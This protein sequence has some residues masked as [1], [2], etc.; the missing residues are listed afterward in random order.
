MHRLSPPEF[1]SALT[2]IISAAWTV[3]SVA[4]VELATQGPLA[5]Y[6]Q[7]LSYDVTDNTFHPTTD[8]QLAPMYEAIFRAAPADAAGAA[9]RLTAW[10]PIIDILL[11]NL[12]RGGLAVSDA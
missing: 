4:A 10:K 11:S 2:S 9:G 3:M 5:G 1:D 8:A 6:F 12:D 7:G